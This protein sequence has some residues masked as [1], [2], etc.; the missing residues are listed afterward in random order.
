MTQILPPLMVAADRGY[1]VNFTDSWHEI[2]LEELNERPFLVFAPEG[3]RKEAE[4]RFGSRELV[5]T[6]D[7]EAQKSVG[8]YSRYMEEIARRGLDRGSV[9]VGIGGGATTDLVGFLAATYMRGIDWIAVPTTVA[10]MVD[11]AIGG[12]AGINLNSGKN[13]AGAFYSP[14]R[15]IVDLSWLGS[16]SSRDMSAGLAESVKCGFIADARIL[17]LI[18][19][20]V[21][22]NL[23]EIIHR[24]VAVKAKVVTA[25]F[26]ESYE[27]EAL[28]YGHTLGH[29]IERHA[30]YQLRHGE[31]ISVGLVFAAKVSER[32]S[33]LDPHITE[34]HSAI[35]G[36]LRLPIAYQ[37]EAWQQ[38]VELMYRDKKRTSARIRFVTLTKLGETERIELSPVE[39]EIL[40]KELCKG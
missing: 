1:E 6:E 27:R 18:D 2:L 8:S 26:R 38:L 39:L 40:Y 14:R 37:E 24:S 7:G 19:S 10:G 28:N 22:A 5:I 12:K 30:N 15:V 11:A 34:R 16:L 31:A 36:S 35:L 33:G 32:Y 25:D 13:L 20:G 4:S 3:L 29:A 17:E 21:T 23:A 9:L